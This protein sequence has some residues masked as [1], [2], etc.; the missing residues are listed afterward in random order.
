MASNEIFRRP[1]IRSCLLGSVVGLIVSV[2]FWLALVT[3]PYIANILAM[4]FLLIPDQLGLVKRVAREDVIG[5][6]V[7]ISHEFELAESGKYFI[8][9][10]NLL[11]ASNRVLIRQQGTDQDIEVPY[12]LDGT[13]PYGP[14]VVEGR[15][16]FAFEVEQAGV[17]E[18]YLQNLPDSAEP[19]YRLSIVPDVIAKNRTILAISFVLHMGVVGLAG[20]SI[21]YRRNKERM[22]R[23]RRAKREKREA[24]EE[25]MRKQ[26]KGR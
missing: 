17:Y 22:H 1:S 26:G 15:P 14:S 19:E 7:P 13:N 10:T 4:P 12:I 20:G 24:F 2:A 8:F 23:E 11:P 18:L 9:S 5:I 6:T 21:Y 16:I 25:W 3:F